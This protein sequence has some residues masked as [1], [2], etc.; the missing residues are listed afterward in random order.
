MPDPKTKAAQVAEEEATQAL[1]VRK[2]AS[3]LVLRSS[4][5]YEFAVDV[6]KQVKAR[7]AE[8]EAKRKAISSG[9]YRSMREVN[10]LFNTPLS[11]LKDTEKSM[12]RQMLKFKEE[13]ETHRHELLDQVETAVAHEDHEKVQELIAEAEDAIVPI[14]SGVSYKESWTGE[15]T[16]V[17]LLP[18]E[19][20]K[21]DLDKLLKLTKKLKADPEIPGWKAVKQ[22]DMAVGKSRE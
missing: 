21:P 1:E 6:L 15:I 12:K 4:N 2:F 18:P 8:I 22:T 14:V 20:L 13:K 3:E 9:L 19:Y 17:S 11:M 7:H 5:D 16:D 10:D